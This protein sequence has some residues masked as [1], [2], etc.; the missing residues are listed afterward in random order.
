MLPGLFCRKMDYE[1]GDI[2]SLKPKPNQQET[3]KIEKQ[4]FCVGKWAPEKVSGRRPGGVAAYWQKPQKIAGNTAFL[5]SFSW[6]KIRIIIHK[7]AAKNILR[8]LG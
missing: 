8:I 2:S 5:Q 3:L 1:K 6:R 4:N 7:L